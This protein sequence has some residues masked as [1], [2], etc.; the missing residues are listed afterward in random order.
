MIKS[1][2]ANAVVPLLLRRSG[3]GRRA[4]IATLL[5]TMLLTSVVA[6]PSAAAA[7]SVN[8]WSANINN[9][10]RSGPS[11]QKPSGVGYRLG[12]QIRNS[13]PGVEVAAVSCG[14]TWGFITP[15]RRIPAGYTSLV[16]LG[17]TSAGG[18]CWRL[19]ARTPGRTSYSYLQFAGYSY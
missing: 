1:T 13:H 16:Q 8:Y 2:V 15:Y 12:V 14:T 6:T 17:Q 3:R 4:A 11:W 18:F 9:V 5:L 19:R 7:T 10:A